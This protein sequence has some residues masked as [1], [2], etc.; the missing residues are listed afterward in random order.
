MEGGW[1]G[2]GGRGRNGR[3]ENLFETLVP[4]HQ[5]ILH[6]LRFPPSFHPYTTKIFVHP[7]SR[8]P[9]LW[10]SYVMLGIDANTD[11]RGADNDYDE[12]VGPSFWKPPINSG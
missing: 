11:M 9:P 8:S 6:Q 5:S 10:G 7:N 4:H 12:F 1:R 3:Q 2:E